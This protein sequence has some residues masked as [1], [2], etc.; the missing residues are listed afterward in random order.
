MKVFLDTSVLVAAI[1]EQ[2]IDHARAFAIL[3]QVQTKKDEGVV[4]AHSL[5]ETY[6]TLTKLPPPFRHSP[7]AALLSIE[8]NILKHFRLV[9]LSST[10][11]SGLIREAAGLGIQGGTVYD[12]LILR[13]AAKAEVERI[14]TLN[15]RHFQPLASPELATKLCVP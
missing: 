3:E 6:A 11:Y 2:H 8:E 9:S 10:D 14:Y 12:A 4:S 1:I 5:A 13:S 15:L 7:A